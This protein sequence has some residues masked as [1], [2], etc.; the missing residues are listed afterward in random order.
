MSKEI[1]SKIELS[2]KDQ[3]LSGSSAETVIS[4]VAGS[5]HLL[6]EFDKHLTP[7]GELEGRG[8]CVTSSTYLAR[9]VER[10][11]PEMEASIE[12]VARSAWEPDDKTTNAHVVAKVVSRQEEYLVDSTPT[13]GPGFGQSHKGLDLHTSVTLTQS[14]LELIKLMKVARHT[15]SFNLS[16]ASLIAR[17][18]SSLQIPKHL[19]S[20]NA[21]LRLMIAR[22]LAKDGN[23]DASLEELKKVIDLNPY[24]ISV[25][26]IIDIL[27]AK[28]VDPVRLGGMR[29]M[30]S[31]NVGRL[32]EAASSKAEEYF[33]IATEYFKGGNIKGG[34]VFLRLGWWVDNISRPKELPTI[35]IDG[36]EAPITE[37]ALKRFV[38]LGLIAVW[39]AETKGDTE[40]KEF[41]VVWNEII[42]LG[43][44][45]KFGYDPKDLVYLPGDFVKKRIRISILRPKDILSI[46]ALE[47]LD[48]IYRA[49]KG[50]VGFLNSIGIAYPHLT[51]VDKFSV[52]SNKIVET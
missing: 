4:H 42:D 40:F 14:D 38:D 17:H 13:F 8:D 33:S 44:E 24:K 43:G 7:E 48:G 2:A 50:V 36:R 23:T 30:I 51:N 16:E 45:C 34:L 29:D 20:W 22:G 6:L 28:M 49:D 52:E 32:V 39:S 3:V 15:S 31:I 19:D 25:L 10:L 12:V 11:L 21:D 26:K 37:L 47:N 18:V 27:A 46:D 41:D 35:S 1:L 5:L 9:L